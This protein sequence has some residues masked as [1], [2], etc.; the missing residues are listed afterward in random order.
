MSLLDTLTSGAEFGSM[1]TNNISSIY[2]VIDIS[3]QNIKSSSIIPVNLSSTINSKQSAK[4]SAPQSF[5]P[6]DSSSPQQSASILNEIVSK[7]FQKNGMLKYFYNKLY[8]QSFTPDINGY[9]LVYLIPP[10]LS[11]YT[12]E[13]TLIDISKISCFL[14]IDATPPDSSVSYQ[15]VT[16]TSTSVIYATET[17]VGK[18]TSVSYIDDHTL[19]MYGMHKIWLD[20]IRDLMIGSIEPDESYISDDFAELDYVGTL[21]YVRFRISDMDGDFFKNIVFIGKAVGV[22][23][24]NMPD[25]E[26][27]GKRDSNELTIVPINYVCSEYR[28]YTLQDELSPS[29]KNFKWVLEDFVADTK[30][31]YSISTSASIGSGSDSIIR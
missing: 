16:G 2:D 12:S 9:T 21:Y 1:I 3:Q 19:S 23:P 13:K 4:S 8:S 5:M 29:N 14:A 27:L 24:I 28:Q 22:F 15:E 26:I 18:S 17:K 31:L 20:Y 7:T 30:D 6:S 10:H 11:G 25:K